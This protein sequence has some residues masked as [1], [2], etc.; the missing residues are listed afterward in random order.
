MLHWRPPGT[1]FFQGWC[2]IQ[3]VYLQV[4][5]NSQYC[6]IASHL[7]KQAGIQKRQLRQPCVVRSKTAL[8]QR[9]EEIRSQLALDDPSG[10]T[11]LRHEVA[12][13]I[14]QIDLARVAIDEIRGTPR[15]KARRLPFDTDADIRGFNVNA[16]PQ[17][18]NILERPTSSVRRDRRTCVLGQDLC[19]DKSR[20]ERCTCSTLDVLDVDLLVL[21]AAVA[22]TDRRVSRHRGTRWGRNLTLSIPMHEPSVWTRLCPKLCVML[23]E[24][25]GD[26]WELSFH[27]RVYRDEMSQQFLRDCDWPKWRVQRSCPTVVDSIPL[28]RWSVIDWRVRTIR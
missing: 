17:L 24:L 16:A 13:T 12:A 26:T 2:L 23:Q 4:Q 25:T 19:F 14:C 28:Q 5:L 10:Y 1:R 15:P 9:V 6:D 22:F 3:I 27:Q 20:L 7:P 11:K 8:N 18:I 21:L